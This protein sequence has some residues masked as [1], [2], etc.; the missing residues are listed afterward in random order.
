MKEEHPRLSHSV[1]FADLAKFD[2]IRYDEYQADR[3]L[4]VGSD[5]SA[6]FLRFLPGVWKAKLEN[7]DDSPHRF[8]SHFHLDAAH[9]LRDGK[10][11]LS[12]Q[13]WNDSGTK[14][15]DDCRNRAT[16][17]WCHDRRRHAKDYPATVS[18]TARTMTRAIQY[19]VWNDGSFLGRRIFVCCLG[20]AVA[21]LFLLGSLP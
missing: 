7:D 8:L 20:Q 18:R 11:I 4:V 1:V 12:N 16:S 10:A 5:G 13:R 9:K 3:I 19:F 14:E 2:T 17:V 21:P 15:E 6:V